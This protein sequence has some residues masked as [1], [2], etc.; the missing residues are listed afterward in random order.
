MGI[1]SWGAILVRQRLA[2]GEATPWHRDPDSS[3]VFTQGVADTSTIHLLDV[4]TS[5]R[6][7]VPGSDGLFLVDC[8]P[9][10]RFIDAASHDGQNLKLFELATGKWSELVTHP[11]GFP[12]WSRDSKYVYF[13]TGASTE[14]AVYRVRIAD[15]GEGPVQFSTAFPL[16]PKS[17]AKVR[18]GLEATQDGKGVGLAES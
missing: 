8:S 13:D 1:L 12:Q 16:N 14:L 11:V 9:D 5:K 15:R 4:K 18:R 10:G 6:E 17:N 7:L 2:P 3:V